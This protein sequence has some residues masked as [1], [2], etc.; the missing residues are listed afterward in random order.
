[1]SYADPKKFCSFEALELT[2]I[3]ALVTQV[4]FVENHLSNN[5]NN[6]T[7]TIDSNVD[8]NSLSIDEIARR[9][10]VKAETLIET[11][12]RPVK[13]EKSK[14]NINRKKF[15]KPPAVEAV[16]QAI[17][18]RQQNM[19]QRAQYHVEQTLNIILQTMPK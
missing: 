12:L 18:D 6:N 3:N 4:L 2:R 17:E 13:E 8:R 10:I 11:Y 1:M 5:D 9:T 7:T 19:V 14:L 15:Q 16:F